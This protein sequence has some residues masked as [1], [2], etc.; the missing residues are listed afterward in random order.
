MRGQRGPRI[1]GRSD[2]PSR[3]DKPGLRGLLTSGEAAG[4]RGRSG[5]SGHLWRLGNPW[6]CRHG[7]APGHC[8]GRG[9]EQSLGTRRP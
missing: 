1:L 6:E 7:S 3:G 5:R 8:R 4:R 2:E 9:V